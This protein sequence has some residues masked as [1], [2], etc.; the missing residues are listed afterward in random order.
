MSNISRNYEEYFYSSNNL[1]ID[2]I[3]LNLLSMIGL[4]KFLEFL[5]NVVVITEELQD[6]VEILYQK[7]I[8]HLAE[9][10]YLGNHP[11]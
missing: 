8:H 10:L 11:T 5:W 4:F 2:K 1:L 3:S 9:N 7:K 6:I